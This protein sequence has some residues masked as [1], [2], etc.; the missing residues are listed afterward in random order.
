[1]NN[2]SPNGIP[3]HDLALKIGIHLVLARNLSL[4]QGLWNGARLKIDRRVL[5][6][7]ILNGN[8]QG[9]KA[10]YQE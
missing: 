7:T 1:M 5:E 6:C 2:H 8:Q 10:L 3:S 4:A 9:N